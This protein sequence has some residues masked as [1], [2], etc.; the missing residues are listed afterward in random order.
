MYLS[1]DITSWQTTF[2]F[3]F[4]FRIIFQI[5]LK[6]ERKMP[7]IFSLLNIYIISSILTLQDGF[8]E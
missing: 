6:K 7:V 8:S 3:S 2:S 5:T 4:I 1:R